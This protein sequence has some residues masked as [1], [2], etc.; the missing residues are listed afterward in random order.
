MQL[1]F[2]KA[3]GIDTIFS[4]IL[5]DTITEVQKSLVHVLDEDL[6][7]AVKNTKYY[8]IIVGESTDLSVHKKLIMYVRYIC[9]LD[10]D[11]K[12]KL[13]G[14][15]RIPDGT[16]CTIVNEVLSEFLMGLHVQQ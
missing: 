16:A 6:I 4:D 7:R 13:L 8:G 10:I 2:W 5:S 14:N 15:V 12:T 1:A 11:V 9:P 3:K